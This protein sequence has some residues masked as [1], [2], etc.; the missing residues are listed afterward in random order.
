MFEEII[1]AQKCRQRLGQAVFHGRVERIATSVVHGRSSCGM[2]IIE[3]LLTATHRN[4]S[5]HCQ[6]CVPLAFQLPKCLFGLLALP[7]QLF[8]RQHGIAVCTPL[9][10]QLLAVLRCNLYRLSTTLDSELQRSA[11]FLEGPPFP[12]PCWLRVSDFARA[13]SWVY[14]VPEEQQD[15]GIY[16]RGT[17]NIGRTLAKEA[18]YHRHP[19]VSPVPP[20]PRTSEISAPGAAPCKLSRAPWPTRLGLWRPCL[21]TPSP[22]VT[23]RTMKGRN[24]RR[25]EASRPVE[26]GGSD[27]PGSRR[28]RRQ[29]RMQ[30]R[31]SA[32]TACQQTD[33]FQ[34]EGISWTPSGEVAFPRTVAYS[35]GGK[36]KR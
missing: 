35:T 27:E 3:L 18:G 19:R 13:D 11:A 10:L 8:G 4:S 36:R 16:L 7:L 31:A 17:D 23:R 21:H 32:A 15:R 34:K 12:K 2:H 5:L 24:G 33:F 25:K 20:I 26:R 28:K 29:A 22:T 14:E 6:K 30:R 9:A 1:Q